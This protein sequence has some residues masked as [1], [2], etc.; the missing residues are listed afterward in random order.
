MVMYSTL[1]DIQTGMQDSL[2]SDDQINLRSEQ[3]DAIDHAKEH[4]CKKK[5]KKRGISV[6]RSY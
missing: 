3:R 4:F 1:E 5:W 2:F 6:C